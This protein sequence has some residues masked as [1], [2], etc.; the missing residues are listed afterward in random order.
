MQV[1]VFLVFKE[2]FFI[3]YGWLRSGYGTLFLHRIHFYFIFFGYI[4]FFL[5][6][7][8]I[9]GYGGYGTFIKN[10]RIFIFIKRVDGQNIA[11]K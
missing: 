10:S 7:Y 11:G 6:L 1:G 9:S 4:T 2:I 3:G 8:I 5:K